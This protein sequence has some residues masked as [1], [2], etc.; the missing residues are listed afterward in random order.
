MKK[1]L[2]LLI[3]ICS[4]VFSQN[5]KKGNKKDS[6]QQNNQEVKSQAVAVSNI[7]EVYY[8]HSNMRCVTCK[9]IESGA[10]TVIEKD[11]INE[12]KEGKLVFKVVNIEDEKNQKITEK[13]QISGSSLLLIKKSDKGI[14]LEKVDLTN[15]AFM[16]AKNNQPKYQAE[17]KSKLL[18]L[19][20]KN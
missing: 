15:F 3:V 9:A 14:D 17:V 16:N 10:K 11:F 12:T 13:Y 4:V 19:L 18:K 5:P 7:V 1:L 8:F 20:G 6:K 2:I